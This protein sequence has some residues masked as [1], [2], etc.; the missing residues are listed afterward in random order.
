MQT[1]IQ[2]VDS[3]AKS[4]AELTG[5]SAR[6][7]AQ[8]IGDGELTALEVI[9]AHVAR[10]TAVNPALNA[11][12]VPRFEAALAEARAA[13]EKR[14]RGEPLGPLHGVPISV[15]ECLDLAGTPS[16]FGMESRRAAVAERDELHVARLRRAGAIVLGKTNVAQALLYFETD[17]PVYG[18]TQNPWDATRTPGGSSGGEAALV[19]TGGS[20]LGVGTD[21]GGS[22]RIPAAFCGIAGLKP[23]AGRLPDPGRG[24]VPFG[25]KAIESQIGLLA[26]NVCDLALALSVANGDSEGAPVMP[27]RDAKSIELEHVRVGFYEDDGT[28]P[29]TAAARRAVREAAAALRA[30]G[31]TVL[32]WT[33]P[34]LEHALD[35][36]FSVLV[37]D[38]L[39]GLS[40]ALGKTARDPRIADLE[41]GASTPRAL[42]PLV[43]WL[44][45]RMHRPHIA[46]IARNH[47]R[48]T[49]GEYW[50]LVERIA[51]YRDAFGLALDTAP[52]GKLDVILCPPSPLPAFRHGAALELATMGSYTP[53]FNVLGYPAGVVPWTRV[54][55]DESEGRPAARDKAVQ[56]ARDAELESAGLPIG[57]QVAA[58]PWREDSVLA[59]MAALET[60]APDVPTLP[61]E[62]SP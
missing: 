24:S 41:R 21:L 14:A 52:G 31:A 7:L 11:V 43:R 30:R 46:R 62:P 45:E 36:F 28:F 47:G 2:L 13:D 15:K 12:C 55:A 22:V 58:R 3:R 53:L 50:D 8:R 61:I 29:A 20:A 9:R 26:R 4:A 60:A 19:A 33:P 44:L 59:V 34:D 23:T 49:A 48:R 54:H 6:E 10:I 39:A 57:V 17:N 35:L 27:L 5:R 1:G 56:A 32:P 51:E 42:L 37:A 18:R 16:T 25:Q 40:R 38:G